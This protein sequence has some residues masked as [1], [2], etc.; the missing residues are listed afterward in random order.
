MSKKDI[1]RFSR[2]SA[3]GLVG[4][5]LSA[6]FVLRDGWGQTMPELTKVPDSLKG[7]G[8][9]RIAT[10]GGTMQE[11]QRKAYF[12]PFEK[13]TGIKVRDFAGSDPTKIKAMVETG[14]IEWD[15]AQLSRG[16]IMNLMKTGDYFE[17][18]DYSLVDDG[19]DKAYRFEYGLEMLV[20]AQVIGYRSD[21]TKGVAPNG[22]ADFW[23]T[24]K[25][26][27]GRTMP[28]GTTPTTPPWPFAKAPALDAPQKAT[29]GAEGAAP[30]PSPAP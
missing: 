9:V 25:F 15:M 10:F 12:E 2:R 17:K 29:V 5:G 24:K 16:S 3:L 11:T 28:A 14:N 27:G 6:P 26:P 8:E 4:A 7:S 18:I 22:W 30:T 19:V 13:A 21:L 20:W 23:D 1:T